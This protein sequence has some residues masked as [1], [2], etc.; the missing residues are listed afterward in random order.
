VVILVREVG[1]TVL[2]FLV[3]R[4]G[5]MPA[6][7]G[8]KVKTALQ[9]VSILLYI[10]PLSDPWHAIAVVVMTMA[11]IVTVVTGIDY[12]LRARTLRNTSPRAQAKRERRAAAAV[13]VAET[14]AR[15]DAARGD[16]ARG[17]AARGDAA[18]GDAARGDA[19]RGD[20]ARGDAARHSAGPEV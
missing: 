1:I 7:R 9:A 10:L 5:V 17:D 3:I 19:A 13:A 4:H 6:S 18:R 16:A 11:V 14:A 8:G 15:E 20:A 2:R 12:V